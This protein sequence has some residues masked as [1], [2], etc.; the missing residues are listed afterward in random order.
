MT[1]LDPDYRIAMEVCSQYVALINL[2]EN[3]PESV[4]VTS[5]DFKMAQIPTGQKQNK[6]A[7]QDRPQ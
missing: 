5:L 4:F 6:Q 7:N 1:V 3:Y 2:H